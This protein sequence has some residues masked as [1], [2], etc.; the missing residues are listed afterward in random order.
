MGDRHEVSAGRR[1]TVLPDL[2]DLHVAIPIEMLPGVGVVAAELKLGL[3]A[4]V[5]ATCTR[6]DS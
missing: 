5:D 2:G 1:I 4:T 3:F 6:N